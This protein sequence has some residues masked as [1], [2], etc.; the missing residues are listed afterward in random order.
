MRFQTASFNQ[1]DTYLSQ[2]KSAEWSELADLLSRT[3]YNVQRCG[4]RNRENELIFSPSMTNAVLREELT[5]MGWISGIKL[6]NPGYDVG[7]DIDF[8]K[9]GILLEI[10]FAH[11]G[12][13]QADI[14]RMQGL[15]QQKY[16]LQN[17]LPVECGIELVVQN[18]MPTSNSVAHFDQATQRAAASATSLPLVIVGLHPPNSG[19]TVIL[20]EVIPRSRTSGNQTNI[21]WP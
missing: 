15:Y 4:Q 12:I 10:Q 7:K 20:H 11:Y 17:H 18:S 8:Y 3:V 9:N 1:G 13:L 5:Q 21:Q 2:H 6:D 14:V 19:E 16:F